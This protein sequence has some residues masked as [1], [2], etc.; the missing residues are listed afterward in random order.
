MLGVPARIG[1]RACLLVALVVLVVAGCGRQVGETPAPT[2]A[3]FEGIVETLQQRGFTVSDLVS[4][5]P[6]CPDPTLVG[7][8]ISARLRGLDQATPVKIH[9]YL[10]RNAAA[11]D[12][13][14]AD[15]D[16][17]LR[18]F[19]VNVTA[20]E[21][22]DASPYVAAGEGPWGSQFRAALRDALIAA[23]HV[24]PS[25]SPPPS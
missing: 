1:A 14:R 4:G 21:A 18:A 2:P 7:P 9:F 22:V 25:S 16:T 15:V 8:A 23:S 19:V 17:C 10:F 20:L 13:R 12:R 11:Y 6:G 24:V 5:D 3:D